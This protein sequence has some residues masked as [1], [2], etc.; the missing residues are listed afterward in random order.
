LLRV[1]SVKSFIFVKE[2]TE[3]SDQHYMTVVLLTALSGSA[4]M[5]SVGLQENI[6][7]VKNYCSNPKRISPLVPGLT[8]KQ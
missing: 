3:E 4:L 8:V 6:E 1:L 5:L 2:R 7:P